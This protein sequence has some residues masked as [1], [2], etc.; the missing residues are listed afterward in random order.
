ML[1]FSSLLGNVEGQ[2]IYRIWY[3]KPASYWEEALP[4]G[5][6]R[7]AAMVFGDPQLEQIQLNEETVSAGSPYQNYNEEAKTALPEMRR[8][9]FEGK[10]EEAQN[11]AATKILSQVGNEMPY[12]T[13]GRLNIRYQDHKKV[14]NYYRD[15][16]ISNA[17][18][19]TRYEVDGVEFT[20]ETFA[21]FTDQLVIRHIKASK[22]GTIN[23]ELFFNTPMRDPKRSI[24]GKK[25]LR[26]EGITHGSRYFPGKVHYCADLDVK[27]KGGKVITAN[28]TLLSVQG[29]SELTLYI[30]M[31]TNFVPQ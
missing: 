9:I 25:G 15:L 16:D 7:I 3:D 14:N 13:V 30:S 29:A 27:H 22:P 11:M 31:A 12:Q 4:V 10:Y 28:D 19:V 1:A 21:S 23:C 6:G 20:E 5:N 8:L 2:N 18:A 26:L 17:V 24:Y